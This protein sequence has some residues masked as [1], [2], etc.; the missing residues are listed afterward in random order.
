M[1]LVLPAL[2]NQYHAVRIK[3]F[4]QILREVLSREQDPAEDSEE[5]VQVID[6]RDWAM[7]TACHVERPAGLFY[8]SSQDC[9]HR[10]I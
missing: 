6:I 3:R 1:E 8:S 5:A 10:V 2:S 9:G 4:I 7:V